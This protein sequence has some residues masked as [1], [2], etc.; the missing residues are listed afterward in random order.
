MN[1]PELSVLVT[2]S[3]SCELRERVDEA[4]AGQT[5]DPGRVEVLVLEGDD[6]GEARNRALARC[7]AP[8][9]LLVDEGGYEFSHV[10]ALA[11]LGA[12][13]SLGDLDLG[14]TLTTPSIV[15]RA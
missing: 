11:K 15:L 5:A 3:A 2:P 14:A 7:A 1:A 10:R 6:V 12:W 8:L 4:L 13:Y 9:A